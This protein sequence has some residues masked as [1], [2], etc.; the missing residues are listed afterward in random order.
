M[1]GAVRGAEVVE[2]PPED[3]AATVTLGP[4]FVVTQ[5]PFFSTAGFSQSASWV[6][7]GVGTGAKVGAAGAATRP[8]SSGPAATKMPTAVATPMSEPVVTARMRDTGTSGARGQGQGVTARLRRR[9]GTSAP[10]LTPSA[11]KAASCAP[12]GRVKEPLAP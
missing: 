2:P 10:I 6:T 7:V 9:G 8:R 3:G 4:G 12:Q 5:M 1:R 11:V